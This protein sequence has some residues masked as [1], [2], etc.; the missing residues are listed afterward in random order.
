[1][2]EKSELIIRLKNS[3]K[4]R[5]AYTRAVI[6]VIVPAQIRGLR[7]K[8]ELTQKALAR[9]ADM[10][11]S[12]ISTME[13]PGAT[14][15][16]VETLIRL[17]SAFKVGL[18][19]EFISFGEMLRWENE[20]SQDAF[21]VVSLDKDAEFQRPEVIAEVENKPSASQLWESLESQGQHPPTISEAAKRPYHQYAEPQP[22]PGA[23]IGAQKTGGLTD[24]TLGRHSS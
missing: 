3:K 24:A 6:N 2:S 8:H 13:R 18:K 9:E 23:M 4:S 19:I 10:K 21:D 12:R 22:I 5:D 1:M 20:F 15:F 17:A 7:F 11:Q 16:N 14:R